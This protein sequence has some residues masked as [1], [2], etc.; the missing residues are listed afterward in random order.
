[1]H[2]GAVATL[3]EL[4]PGQPGTTV[5]AHARILLTLAQRSPEGPGD[6]GQHDEVM[7][8]LSQDPDPAVALV[9]SIWASHAFENSGDLARAHRSAEQALGWCDPAEGPWGAASLRAQLAGLE[10]QAGR[11]QEAR[12]HADEALPTLIALGAHEDAAQL[13]AV[14]AL[15]ALREGDFDEADRLLD[16]VLADDPSQSVFGAGVALTCGRAEVLLARGRTSEGLDCYLEGVQEIRRRTMSDWGTAGLGDLAG[17][18]PWVLL[19]LAAAIAARV[20]AGRAAEA[21]ADRHEVL[22]QAQ[23]MLGADHG[24]LDFPVVGCILA[25]LAAWEDVLGTA[26]VAA[27]LI[28]LAE[29]FS[30]NR[31]LPSL[32]PGWGEPLADPDRVAHYRH[33]HAGRRP[34]EL[35]SHAAALLAALLAPRG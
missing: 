5:A 20:R 7:V 26:E 33:Q 29:T 13:R 24:W 18:E 14:H 16:Q 21:S 1:M 4:G 25:G 34:R 31:M 3:R 30:L 6:G 17:D 10:L 19:P 23:V 2:A 15:V 9:A 35:R 28:A 11:W 8:E 32:D 12:R 27:E 22:A